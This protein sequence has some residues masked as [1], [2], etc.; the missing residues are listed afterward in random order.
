[1]T[2]YKKQKKKKLSKRIRIMI[3]EH[4]RNNRFGSGET[5]S[6]RLYSRIVIHSQVMLYKT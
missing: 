4:L 2:I 1:M 5:Y 3:M 6:H